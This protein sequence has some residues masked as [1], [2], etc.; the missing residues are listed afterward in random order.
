MHARAAH[1]CSCGACV[2]RVTMRIHTCTCGHACG[3]KAP[4]ATGLKGN[5]GSTCGRAGRRHMH[6]KSA[7]MHAD[8]MNS[9]MHRWIPQTA[10]CD[11]A[12]VAKPFA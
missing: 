8:L 1:T 9:S 3:R 4:T 7:C 6:E 11:V 12:G 5:Q 10:R 2:P